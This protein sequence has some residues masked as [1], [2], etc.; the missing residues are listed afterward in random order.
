MRS[1][2]SVFPLAL[3][4]LVAAS[5]ASRL[6]AQIARDPIRLTHGPMLGM[7]TS[8]SVRVWG[9]T[10]DEGKFEVHYGMEPG[11][12]SESSRAK[13]N[14]DRTR[15][16]GCGRAHGPGPR[17]AI[18]LSDFRQ[19]SPPW[20][21]GFFSNTAQQGGVLQRPVQPQGAVQLSI[22]DRF[23]REPESAARRR[24]SSHHVRISQSRLG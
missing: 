21:A 14:V 6:P 13:P 9:R 7:V 23:L 19:W 3:T 15:Q 20:I 12:L 18:S 4:L 1:R 22:R 24:S 2:F 5:Q 10:S 17:Y 16:H 11:Q 8:D